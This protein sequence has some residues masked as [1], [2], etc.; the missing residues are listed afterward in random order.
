MEIEGTDGARPFRARVDQLSSTPLSLVIGMY[1]QEHDPRRGR[2]SEALERQCG[3]A[4]VVAED[5]GLRP[6]AAGLEVCGRQ[7]LV[8]ERRSDQSGQPVGRR[9][10]AA[11]WSSRSCR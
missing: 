6:V 1:R 8:R 9:R 4:A 2:V 10:H 3:G 5:L 7:Q 11:R